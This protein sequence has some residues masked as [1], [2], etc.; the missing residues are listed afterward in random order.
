MRLS[1]RLER[2]HLVLTSVWFLRPHHQ[3]FIEN[4]SIVEQPRQPCE[5][6]EERRY[7]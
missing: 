3:S 1:S 7:K 4:V 2:R 5:H 6:T